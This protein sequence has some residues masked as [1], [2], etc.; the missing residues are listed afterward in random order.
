MVKKSLISSLLLLSTLIISPTFSANW[1]LDRG[2]S[3]FYFLFQFLNS[4]HNYFS[5]V[6]IV[7]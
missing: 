6:S 7:G 3:Y 1:A 5:W 4:K 2:V